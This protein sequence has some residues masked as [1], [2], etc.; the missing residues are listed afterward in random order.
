MRICSKCGSTEFD[1]VYYR[2]VRCDQPNQV[3]E[4]GGSNSPNDIKLYPGD[5]IQLGAQDA[6]FL[7]I[8]NKTYSG[9]RSVDRSEDR[10]VT[11]NVDTGKLCVR[12]NDELQRHR[13]AETC[14]PGDALAIDNTSEIITDGN[15]RVMR[16]VYTIMN[17]ETGELLGITSSADVSRKL[18]DKA[19]SRE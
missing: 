11:V 3:T 18:V 4:M 2:C 14:V 19:P 8:N 13:L 5:V 16:A 10:K 17:M 12:T 6:V 9:V 15:M 1:N 7:V